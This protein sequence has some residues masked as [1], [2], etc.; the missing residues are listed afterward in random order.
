MTENN[1][2]KV[3]FAAMT[4]EARAEIARLGGKAAA[5]S[6]R[7]HRW[8]KETAREAARKSAEVRRVLDG[9]TEPD[10]PRIEPNE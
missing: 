5:R 7:S 8:T 9:T 1:A 10:A 4:P 3:G 2:K 6:G